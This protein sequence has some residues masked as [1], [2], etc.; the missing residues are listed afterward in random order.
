MAGMAFSVTEGAVIGLSTGASCL[1]WC[2]P[3]LGPYVATRAESG[4][5]GLRAVLAF[6]AGRLGGYAAVL[7]G[8]VLLGAALAEAAWLR[9]VSAGAL[10]LLGAL[11]LLHAVRANFPRGKLCRSERFGRLLD[12]FPGVAGLLIGLSPCPPLLLAA[13]AIVGRGPAQGLLFAG[14]FFA[15]TSLFLLPMALLGHRRV[16]SVASGVA[17]GLALLAAP[18]FIAHGVAMLTSRGLW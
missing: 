15:A 4:R 18:W 3:A 2:L 14:A 7:M 9:P 8:S 1:G 12:R 16:R 11:L 5:E 17:G 6:N 13:A 10:V